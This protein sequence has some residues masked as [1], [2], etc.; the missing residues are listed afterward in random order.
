MI[1]SNPKIIESSMDADCLLRRTP[2]KDAKLNK[3][4]IA[5]M[6]IA[7]NNGSYVLNNFP[8]YN[9]SARAMIR[10]DVNRTLDQCL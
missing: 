8:E 3:K 7:G 6:N 9:N 4:K 2:K 5:P 10:N 1:G